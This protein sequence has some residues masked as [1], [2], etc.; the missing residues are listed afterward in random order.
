MAK[1]KRRSKATQRTQISNDNLSSYLQDF[2][3]DSLQGSDRFLDIITWNIK[4]FN[5]RDPKRV[6]NILNILRELNA[7]ILY[8]KK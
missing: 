5:N 7:D 8:F 1:K 6:E 2:V 4:F 3:P